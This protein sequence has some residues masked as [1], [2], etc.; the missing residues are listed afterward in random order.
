MGGELASDVFRKFGPVN[1]LEVTKEK[2]VEL[3]AGKHVPATQPAG[4]RKMFSGPVRSTK[5]RGWIEAS[6]PGTVTKPNATPQEED[7]TDESSPEDRSE[8]H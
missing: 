2:M 4:R 7:G 8:I 6:L 3:L 1:L 5:V